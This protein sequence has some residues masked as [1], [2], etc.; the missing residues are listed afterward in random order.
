[1]LENKL[2]LEVGNW[3]KG[4]T[5][6][7]ELVIGYI[8]EINVLRNIDVIEVM[9]ITSDNNEIVGQTIKML[10]IWLEYLPV[11][12]EKSEGQLLSLIDLAL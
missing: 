3:V 11:S 5:Q 8:E 7:G 1:M 9:V 4:R 6:N 12:S 10:D 2:R